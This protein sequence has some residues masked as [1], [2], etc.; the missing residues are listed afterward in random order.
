MNLHFTLAILIVLL[1][2]LTVPAQNNPVA[3]QS[4]FEELATTLVTLSSTQE[5]ELLLTKKRDLMTPDLRKALIRQGNVH[6]LAGRYSAA[7]DIYGLAQN[8]A[9]QI[10]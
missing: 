10:G 4:D 1:L 8:I 5:R 6:L 2:S 9:E 7:F 3:A